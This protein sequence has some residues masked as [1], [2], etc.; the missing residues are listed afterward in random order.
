[1]IVNIISCITNTIKHKSGEICVGNK[2]KVMR[3]PA[4]KQC[5]HLCLAFDHKEYNMY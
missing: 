5:Y 2:G 3:E 4:P 1:M